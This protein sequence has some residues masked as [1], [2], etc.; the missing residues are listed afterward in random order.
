MRVDNTL[1]RKHN[2]SQEELD[3]LH[4]ELHRRILVVF[5]ATKITLRSA[6]V[7]ANEMAG[8]NL[9][10]DRETLNQILQ[11]VLKLDPEADY[12]A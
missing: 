2:L 12:G 10:S 5:P 7:P 1:D 11:E 6:S 8:L 9:A 3:A 4:T